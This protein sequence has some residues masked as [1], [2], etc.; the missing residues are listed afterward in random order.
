MRTR[1]AI[2]VDRLGKNRSWLAEQLCI[3]PSH[4]SR[5]MLGTHDETKLQSRV[6]DQIAVDAGHADLTA[7]RF[8]AAPSPCADADLPAVASGQSLVG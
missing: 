3:S 2:L 6:L 5:L 1:S 4:A 7:A 8:G